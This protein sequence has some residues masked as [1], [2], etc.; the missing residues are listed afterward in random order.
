M[1]VPS[2]MLIFQKVIGT[3]FKEEKLNKMIRI[4]ALKLINKY[5]LIEEQQVEIYFRSRKFHQNHHQGSKVSSMAIKKY[6]DHQ[7]DRLASVIATKKYRNH[8]P[9]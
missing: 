9:E 5:K 6:Q 2:Q 8:H 3:T 1:I 4:Q 7:Q